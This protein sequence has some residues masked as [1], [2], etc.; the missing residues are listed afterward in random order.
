MPS[1]FAVAA[2]NSNFT[3]HFCNA[4]DVSSGRCKYFLQVGETRG[5]TKDKISYHGRLVFK[6]YFVNFY[7]DLDISS[8]T[9]KSLL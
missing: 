8:P 5:Q 3:L 9:M 2:W 6:L 1:N 7:Y 4:L